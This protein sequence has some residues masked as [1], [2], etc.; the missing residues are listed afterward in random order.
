M[1]GSYRYRLHPVT[2]AAL[3]AAMAALIIPAPAHAQNLLESL[4]NA[5][6]GSSAPAPVAVRETNPNAWD[7]LDRAEQDQQSAPSGPQTSYC[8]RMCDGRY[9]PLPR[10][11]G[12]VSMSDAQICSAMC[13]AAETRVFNGTA[14]ERAVA[15]DGKAYSSIDNA[16][17]YRERVIDSCTCKQSGDGVASLDAMRDPTLRRGDIVVTRNGPMVYAGARRGALRE[18]AFVKPDDYR[19]LPQSVRN[20]LAGMRIAREPNETAMLPASARA[21]S[22]E[23]STPRSISYAPLRLKSADATPVAEAFASFVK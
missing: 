9:F 16:F 3:A 1:P 14:I 21:T 11:A 8:V 23:V 7:F 2:V 22:G 4:F 5:L 17:V 15:E 13:P 18:Q 12:A 10:R 20:E 6:S 19:G